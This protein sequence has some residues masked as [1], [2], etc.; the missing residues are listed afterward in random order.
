[1]P[2]PAAAPRE[3]P[4]AEW[5]LAPMR[6]PLLEPDGGDMTATDTAT[7]APHAPETTPATE[8]RGDPSRTGT[9]WLGATGVA[10][11]LAAAGVL[12]AVRWG[13]IGQTAKLGGFAMV[14]LAMLVGGH[15]LRDHLPMTG[16]AVFHLGALLIPLDMAAVAVLAD[17]SWQDTLLL[18]AFAALAGWSVASQL[19]SS[20]VLRWAR[21]LAVVGVAAG[22]AAV[23]SWSMPLAL[24][25]I[26]AGALLVGWVLDGRG[27][28]APL[29]DDVSVWAAVA[30]VLPLSAFVDWPSRVAGAASDLGL[31]VSHRHELVG[32]GILAALVAAGV[33]ARR[34]GLA[35]GWSTV[36]LGVLPAVVATASFDV[37]GLGPLSAAMT[38][39]VGQFVLLVLAERADWKP[40]AGVVGPAGEMIAAPLA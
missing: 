31:S 37:E 15:R 30:G 34:P 18:T 25:V 2:A 7:D 4:R 27:A 24:V 35:R 19:D 26:A 29:L 13:E 39:V 21:S 33:T 5:G 1:M 12:T 22:V 16:R 32:A 6:P 3:S 23:S 8:E 28:A 11:L 38:F 10:M 17:R 40:I 20:P 9:L 36:V 14:T